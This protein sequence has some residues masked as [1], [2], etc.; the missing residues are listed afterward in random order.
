MTTDFFNGTMFFGSIPMP[1]IKGMASTLPY[2]PTTPVKE[3]TFFKV[4]EKTFMCRDSAAHM[5]AIFGDYT[6]EGIVQLV[7]EELELYRMLYE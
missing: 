3:I 1:N 7:D 5:M 6:Y 2:P 4:A